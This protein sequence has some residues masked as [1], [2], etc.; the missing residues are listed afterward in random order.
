M[1][2]RRINAF[3][4]TV[5]SASLAVSGCS[6]PWQRD[7]VQAFVAAF[8]EGE[9]QE[10][11]GATSDPQQALQDLE[12]MAAGIGESSVALSAGG[13]EDGAY[14]IEAQWTVPSGAQFSTTGSASLGEASDTMVWDA[15]VFDS[16]LSGDVSFVYSDDRD[17]STQLLDRNGTDVMEWTTVQVVSAG[18]DAI[19]RAEEIAAAVNPVLPDVTPESVRA[20][21]ESAGEDSTVLYTFRPED[22]EA[23]GSALSQIEELQVSEQG[24]MLGAVREADSPLEGGLRDYWLEQITAAAGWTLAAQTPDG[25]VV[26]GQEDADPVEPLRTTL[27]LGVQTAANRALELEERPAAIV[28]LSA[29]TGGVIAVSQND[30]ADAKGPIA[31][32]GLYPPGSTFKTV[33]TAAALQR[34]TVTANET[35]ACPAVAEIDGRVIP[36]DGEFD[37]GEV[38]MTEAFAQSCNTTQGFISQD[39]QPEDLPNMAA[40]MGIGVDF[41]APGMTTVTGAVPATEPGAARV[42]AAIGQGEVLASPFGLAVMEATLGNGGRMV[43][44]SIMQGEETTAD[45][46]PEPIDPAVVGDIRDMMAATVERGTASSL[47]YIEDLGGKTGTAEVGDGSSHGWFTGIKGDLA[48]AVFV[49][50]GGSSAPAVQATERFLTNPAMEEWR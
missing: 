3:A 16:Q 33:T 26:L 41:Q 22:W 48:F 43:L 18:P 4:A 11:A 32:T 19:G 37:L 27:D 34:G 1:N 50:G 21:I 12:E 23:V 13:E 39:L 14:E 47:S 49:E 42:E 35:V 36:N 30:A 31:L 8:N 24:Q 7:G 2:R 45:Q 17:V 40:Q 20:A 10:A 15:S 46:Q 28:A 5:L 29:S 44:P 9:Y 25:R 38:S 6:V